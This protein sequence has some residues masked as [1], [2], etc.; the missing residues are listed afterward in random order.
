[1]IDITALEIDPSLSDPTDLLGRADLLDALEL[2]PGGVEMP[3]ADLLARATALRARAEAI[4]VAIAGELRARIVA[5]SLSA[6]ALRT[7][8]RRFVQPPG[9]AGRDADDQYD[10]LDLLLGRLLD[11]RAPEGELADLPPE[12][13]AYQPTPARHLLDLPDRLGL[14]AADTFV[15][16]GAGMGQVAALVALLSDAQALGIEIDPAYVAAARHGAA[17]LGLGRAQFLAADVLTADLRAGTVFYLYTPLRGE[18]LRRMLARLGAE[19]ASRPIRVCA[20]GP[21]VPEVRAQP[22][23]EPVGWCGPIM[24]GRSR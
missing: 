11:L 24:L 13:V 9:S 22:W 16:I 15:D 23:L 4:D 10:G 21:C 20:Y 3:S 18:L 8:L 7:E 17:R 14:S 19:A 6:A 5:G 1:M 2:W 12:M